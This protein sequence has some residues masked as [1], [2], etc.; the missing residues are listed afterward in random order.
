MGRSILL[1]GI[2][3]IQEESEQLI[4]VICYEILGDNSFRELEK[5]L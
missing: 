5:P 2:T 1:H 3:I 4:I